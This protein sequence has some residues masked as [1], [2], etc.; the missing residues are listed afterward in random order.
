MNETKQLFI[1]GDG[2]T[3]P[4]VEQGETFI[5]IPDRRFEWEAWDGATD[6]ENHE[7]T[8]RLTG[9]DI[10][11][12][13]QLTADA[14]GR[15]A[16][17]KAH[18]PDGNY[19]CVVWA[20]DG[21]SRFLQTLKVTEYGADEAQK[22]QAS[23]PRQ[24]PAEYAQKTANVKV[25]TKAMDLIAKRLGEIAGRVESGNAQGAEILSRAN[26]ITDQTTPRVQVKN[27]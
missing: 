26:T 18:S 19:M 16:L 10:V 7:T 2:K 1:G 17:D 20:A 22:R 4:V 9:R 11:G 23:R 15:I 24:E 25:Q 12:I 3:F 13:A 6:A 14:D 27:V 8:E 5:G 21:R